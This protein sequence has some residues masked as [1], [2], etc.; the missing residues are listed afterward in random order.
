MYYMYIIEQK[1]YHLYT[2]ILPTTGGPRTDT[3]GKQVYGDVRQ[4]CITRVCAASDQHI[5][6]VIHRTQSVINITTIFSSMYFKVLTS[7]DKSDTNSLGASIGEPFL[8][9][10]ICL[11]FV[12][13][14]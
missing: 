9:N 13:V 8:A 3:R 4:A 1:Q 5:F 2:P 7:S 12:Y 10:Y 11:L 14:C 6:W